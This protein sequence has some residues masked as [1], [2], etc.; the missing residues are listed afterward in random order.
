MSSGMGFAQ[1]LPDD[2]QQDCQCRRCIVERQSFEI[3]SNRAR[4]GGKKGR[5][6]LKRLMPMV[7]RRLAGAS[8]SHSYGRFPSLDD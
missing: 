2:G 7:E 6:A 1:W 8:V 5:R 3:L 4:Y